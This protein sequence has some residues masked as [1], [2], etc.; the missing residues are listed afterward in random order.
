MIYTDFDSLMTAVSTAP[1]SELENLGALLNVYFEAERNAPEGVIG[2]GVV[3]Y[4]EGVL[5]DHQLRA[6]HPIKLKG[7]K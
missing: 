5:V 6:M 2:V 7:F 4:A 1:D 3:T